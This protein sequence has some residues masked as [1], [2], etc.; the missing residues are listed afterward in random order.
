MS[1]SADLAPFFYL[2]LLNLFCLTNP[3]KV[4]I[5][6]FLCRIYSEFDSSVVQYR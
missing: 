5:I 2:V 1:Q 6:D 4:I 3:Q